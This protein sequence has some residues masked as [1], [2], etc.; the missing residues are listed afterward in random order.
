MGMSK[1]TRTTLWALVIS[2]VAMLAAI[3]V[4]GVVTGDRGGAVVGVVGL[5][6][7]IVAALVGMALYW[8]PSFIAAKRRH[9][10]L[11]P[12]LLVNLFFGWTLIGWVICLAWSCSADVRQPSALPS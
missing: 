9:R 2:A 5:G 10:N 12:I 4:F 8:L 3:I 1:D 6:G 7:M 11:V